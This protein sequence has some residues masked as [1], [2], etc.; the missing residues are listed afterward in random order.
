MGN[1]KLVTGKS[2]HRDH[3]SLPPF[4]PTSPSS[5]NSAKYLSTVGWLIGVAAASCPGM[6]LLQPHSWL[7][8]NVLISLDA[9]FPF[10]VRGRGQSLNHVALPPVEY[11]GFFSLMLLTQQLWLLRVWLYYF[12]IVSILYSV[13]E[14]TAL[15]LSKLSWWTRQEKKFFKLHSNGRLQRQHLSLC[16]YNSM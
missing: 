12:K 1:L 5:P 13:S 14:S 8:A 2:Y 11:Q 4:I 7:N 9:Q 15:S 3:H 6:K 10:L 16:F